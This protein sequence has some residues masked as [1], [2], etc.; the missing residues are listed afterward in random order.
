[1]DS[2]IQEILNN[3]SIGRSE[4]RE[5]LVESVFSSYTL[6]DLFTTLKRVKIP[7]KII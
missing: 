3:N 2:T 4:L 6:K 1:M 7:N 5:S